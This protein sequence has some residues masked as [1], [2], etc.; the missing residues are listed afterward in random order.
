MTEE[1]KWKRGDVAYHEKYGIVEIFE[2][3]QVLGHADLFVDE[4][5]FPGKGWVIVPI[6]ELIKPKK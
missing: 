1:I 6:N 2:V 4:N 5:K 3:S